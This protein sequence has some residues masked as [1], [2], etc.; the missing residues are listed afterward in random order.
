MTAPQTH[1]L[2]TEALTLVYDNKPVLRDIT[3]RIP[4]GR[5]TAIIGP[6]GCGKSTLLRGLTRILQPKSGRVTLDGQPI[7][8]LA[9]RKVAREIG[10]L[11]QVPVAP[12]AITTQEL[13]ARGRTP[14]QSLLRRWDATDQDA[15]DQALAR[16]GLTEMAAHPLQ[17]L[18][19]GQRQRAWIAMVLCQQTPILILDE[20]TTF[21]DLRH[22]IEVLNLLQG[23]TSH[24]KTIV[25]VLHDLNLA[26]RF[27]DHVITVHKGTIRHQGTPDKV[28]Q[29]PI[30]KEVFDLDCSI[31]PDPRHGTPLILPH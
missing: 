18:S 30:I 27:A 3:L 23:L 9:S 21:L 17:T 4:D 19:G 15:V 6:N 1:R 31:I 28:F 26:A 13:V 22:Q 10:M 29:T 5:F 14:Y 8:Q 16:T 24:G 2:A 7:S 11:P 20:P 25:A 12:V